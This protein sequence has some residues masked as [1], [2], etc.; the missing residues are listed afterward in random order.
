MKNKYLI[1]SALIILFLIQIYVPVSLITDREIVL[2]NGKEYRFKTSPIDPVDPF[3]GNYLILSFDANE[4]IVKTKADWTEDESIYVSLK[5]DSMGFAAIASVEK[6][7]PQS[8]N[9]YIKARLANIYENNGH[10]TLNIEYPF[11]RYYMDEFKAEYS[12]EVYSKH[13]NDSLYPA[14]AIVS[15]YNGE[16][17]LKDVIV[18]DKPIKAWKQK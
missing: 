17:V 4:F 13:A 16:S 15:V 7:K 6:N 3:R 12:T 14:Y 1:I 10:F 2:K 18:G 8:A 9:D 5:K 11:D